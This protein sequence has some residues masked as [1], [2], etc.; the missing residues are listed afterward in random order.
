M[1]HD[2]LESALADPARRLW[3]HPLP[4]TRC[5][6]L[7]GY[8]PAAHPAVRALPFACV[9]YNDAGRDGGAPPRVMGT[10]SLR[11]RAGGSG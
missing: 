9:I 4:V 1:L 5:F 8:T 10:A 7:R 11:W 2:L 3:Q 6:G